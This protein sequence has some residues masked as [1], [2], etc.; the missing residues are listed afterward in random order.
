MEEIERVV[1]TLIDR[2]NHTHQLAVYVPTTV[3]VD[4]AA[5][6]TP[7]IERTLAFLGARF[8]G[9]TSTPA[10]GVWQSEAVGLVREAVHV[11]QTYATG[12]DLHRYLPEVLAY[13]K[14]IKTELQQEAM[15]LEVD[16]Q[17]ML[18]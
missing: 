12:E 15:A 3:A 14:M 13:V 9:A 2:V 1:R 6:T 7:Y 11:V 18:L 5:D 8:G 16:H 17:L 10:Q 4:R